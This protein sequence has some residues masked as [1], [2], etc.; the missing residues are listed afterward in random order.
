MKRHVT[1]NALWPVAWCCAFAQAQPLPVQTSAQQYLELIEQR[2]EEGG[3]T[4]PDLLEP[5][6]ALGEEY[7]RQQ[8][9]ALAAENFARARQILRVNNGFDT[10]QELP[11]LAKQVSAEEL[12]GHAVT[13]WELEATL[14]ELARKNLGSLEALPVFIA[15]A[16]KRLDIRRRYRDGE[17]PP[18]IEL[19][20][21]YDR[22]AYIAAVLRRE[23][24]VESVDTARRNCTAGDRRTVI[25]SLLV[26]ARS[27]YLLGVETLLQNDRYASEELMDLMT[28]VL[29]TSNAIQRSE[30]SSADP[31]LGE[32]MVRLLK[33]EPADRA[34]TVRRAEFLLALADMNVV[35]MHDARRMTG[36][37]AVH[38]QYTQV[39]QELS[40]AGVEQRQLDAMFAP[41]IPVMLP[42]FTTNWLTEIAEADA[43]GYIDI[44]FEITEQGKSR[45]IEVIG[46][47]PNVERA[48]IKDLERL[49]DQA[50]FR[51][52]MQDGKLIESAPVS[53]RYYLSKAAVVRDG[54]AEGEL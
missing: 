19:G 10:P 7:F 52:R 17:H 3:L 1:T 5:L 38:E 18:E 2:Q 29:R 45:R 31:A 39:W 15:A 25:N 46:S 43:T 48:D 37:D 41:E 4:A 35:R 49:V 32:L 6:T 50:S 14:L 54:N 33:H 20:C 8:E 24:V 13:A 30:L 28:E 53:V 34:S 27:Y 12:Q 47:S 16:E 40:K 23:P 21:Y 44:R 22:R 42:A 26:E 11:L 9:Y 36:L 51:P